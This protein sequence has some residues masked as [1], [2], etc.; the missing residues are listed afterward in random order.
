MIWLLSFIFF[1]GSE[2]SSFAFSCQIKKECQ[3]YS[4]DDDKALAIL[5]EGTLVELLSLDEDRTYVS[6]GTLEGYIRNEDLECNSQQF[7]KELFNLQGQISLLKDNVSRLGEECISLRG[8]MNQS[9]SKKSYV[10]APSPSLP[11]T[12]MSKIQFLTSRYSDKQ[13]PD[14][15]RIGTVIKNRHPEGYTIYMLEV[16][17]P[18]VVNQVRRLG[19]GDAF[20]ID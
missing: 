10:E 5:T 4:L 9:Q 15:D 19:Y 20:L 7:L 6:N 13:F 18:S 16:N 12:Q 2:V 3:L 1:I 8:E 14:L 11:S 17:D